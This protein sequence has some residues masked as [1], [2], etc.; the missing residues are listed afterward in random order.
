MTRGIRA[1][2]WQPFRLGI[3][4]EPAALDAIAIGP[5]SEVAVSG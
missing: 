5:W 1:L 4:P 2:R 3:V